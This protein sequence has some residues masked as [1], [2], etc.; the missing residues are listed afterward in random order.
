[1]SDAM[2]YLRLIGIKMSRT[3]SVTP[4]SEMQRFG[5]I[6]SA[7]KRSIP[8]ISPAVDSVMRAA[9][10]NRSIRT[11]TPPL[12]YSLWNQGDKAIHAILT[13]LKV[14]GAQAIIASVS[15]RLAAKWK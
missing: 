4:V 12:L 6:G 2:G 10:K 7:A 14:R 3:A 13:F 15:S 11:G 9:G 5:N 1:M 8:G